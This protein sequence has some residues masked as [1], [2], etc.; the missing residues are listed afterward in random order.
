MK[1]SQFATVAQWLRLETAAFS[2]IFL[3][4]ISSSVTDDLKLFL[5]TCEKVFLAYLFDTMS[6]SY[7]KNY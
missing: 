2:A 4:K 7:S 5:K 3:M 6:K 1:S